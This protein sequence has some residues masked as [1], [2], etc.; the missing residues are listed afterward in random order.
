MN[1][2]IEQDAIWQSFH[3]RFLAEI[4]DRL[5]EQL[6]PNYIIMIDEHVYV[7]ELPDAPRRLVGRADV[8]VAARPRSGDAGPRAAV[9]ALEAP[10]EVH[11][12]TQDTQRVPFLEVRDR[13]SR[14]LI[15]VLEL[16]SP[17]NKRGG[18]DRNQYLAKRNRLLASESALRGDRPAPGRA[19]DAP[20]GSARL[21]LFGPGQPGRGSPPG[22]L[23]ADRIRK[24]LPIIPIPLRRPDEFARLDLQEVLDHVYDATGYEDFIYAGTPEPPSRPGMPPGPSDSCRQLTEKR[25]P[26]DLH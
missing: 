26:P 13:Q 21:R 9:G 16:L 22:R 8:S 4:S 23:L 1:P 24:R 15:A 18:S 6:R 17:S 3:L 25:Y 12:P 20:G 2:Y 14:E 19:V 7:H 10:S 11:L 5:V